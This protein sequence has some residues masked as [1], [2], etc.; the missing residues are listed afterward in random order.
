MSRPLLIPVLALAFAPS[1]GTASLPVDGA[2]DSASRR[3]PEATAASPARLP[4]LGRFEENRGQAP[5]WARFVVRTA[6]YQAAITDSGAV[7]A[8]P[9]IG[10]SASR[11]ALLGFE[12][13]GAVAGGRFRADEPLPGVANH[14]MGNDPDK[15]VRGARSFG[16]LTRRGIRPGVDLEWSMC[17]GSPEYR[18]EVSPD[19]DPG[20]IALRFQGAD[21]LRVE[22]D[23]SLSV[24]TRAGL[25]RHGRPSAWQER[26]G[27]RVAVP[28]A[29]DLRGPSRVGFRLGP[30][31]PALALTIDPVISFACYYGGTGGASVRQLF[32]DP[33]G[34]LLVVGASTGTGLALP[35]AL[36]ES[37]AKVDL[38]LAKFGPVGS[39]LQ[40]ATYIGGAEDELF[41]R[42]AIDAGGSLWLAGST[43]SPDFP[44]W[45]PFQ[46]SIAGLRDAFVLRLT[47]GFDGFEF[48]TYLGGDQFAPPLD[49]A[50]TGATGLAIAPGGDAFVVGNTSAVDLPLLDPFQS[51]YGG[52]SADG[53]VARFSGTGEL[54][55]STY[56]GGNSN[57]VPTAVAVDADGAAFVTGWT[58]SSDFPEVAA[59]PGL[60]G[61]GMDAILAKI[62]ADGTAL[63][64]CQLL[65]GSS[66]DD[67]NAIAILPS[68]DVVIGGET[69]SSAFPTVGALQNR[70]FSPGN[71]SCA[72]L[73]RFSAAGDALLFSSWIG[74]NDT[75]LTELE[76]GSDGSLLTAGIT[77]GFPGPMVSPVKAA[78]TGTTDAYLLRLLSDN[79]GFEFSTYVGGSGLESGVAFASEASGRIWIGGSTTS[80]DIPVGPQVVGLLNPLGGSGSY[81]MLISPT[82]GPPGRVVAQPLSGIRS[83]IRWLDETDDETGFE[84]QRR[85]GAG[86][87][88]T[89]ATTAANATTVEDIFLLPLTGY[90]YRVRALRPGGPTDWSD[91]ALTTTLDIAPQPPNSVTVVSTSSSSVR[92]SWTHGSANADGFEI[93]RR[94]PGGTSFLRSVLPAGATE[95]DDAGLPP[96]G[97]VGYVVRAQNEIGSASSAEAWGSTDGTLT[98]SLVRG[99]IK[100]KA[101]PR[102][103][104]LTL[105]GVFVF[106]AASPDAALDP[107]TDGFSVRIGD[108]L[109]P[110][111][112]L[113][114]PPASP[115]WSL[116][117]GRYA[118]RASRS[119]PYRAS[120]Q[121]RPVDG[122]FRL[123]VSGADF[124]VAV[125]LAPEVRIAS[126]NDAGAVVPEWEETKPDSGYLR[127]PPRNQ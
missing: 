104:S 85:Q 31:D 126:G 50:T 115:G 84:V 110:V 66:N 106:D 36:D 96:A 24:K 112:V 68:G 80:D 28:V 102:R 34:S 107:I 79:S 70:P 100:S 90:G 14:L 86:V 109:A 99:A 114:I 74:G 6:G 41:S 38:F 120:L 87:F 37:V 60:R 35:G 73:S 39:T 18:F 122:T 77:R 12:V 117:N 61:S 119:A 59:I 30:H 21:S 46:G 62:S 3:T 13:E 97:T 58:Q 42:A 103:D 52:L 98:A 11:C 48:S 20:A 40:V 111:F 105:K 4:W 75:T 33:D 94:V 27:V 51:T 8:L 127:S 91:E 23:G 2:R 121:V 64:R 108:A 56:L 53:F 19:T 76:A 89:I 95:F 63:E 16:R 7:F 125:P 49:F 10:G 9:G 47:P 26:R 71:G 22:T 67:A 113:E 124:P 1:L 45:V 55:S 123:T 78:V 44:V 72:F 15:W 92:V 57:E 116:R 83:R 25:L 43:F 17:D 5:P 118:W 32:P 93:H 88:F 65:G 82:T 69:S 54:L 81:L 29:F 101:R